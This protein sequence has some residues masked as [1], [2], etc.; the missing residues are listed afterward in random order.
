[1]NNRFPIIRST[2]FTFFAT[3][4]VVFGLGILTSDNPTVNSRSGPQYGDV[5]I[6]SGLSL[7]ALGLVL[8][9]QWAY[10]F[11]RES[12]AP[13]RTIWLISLLALNLFTAVILAAALHL[14]NT[15]HPL[16]IVGV[17]IGLGVCGFLFGRRFDRAT[18]VAE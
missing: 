15:L 18:G 16:A 3:F 12:A 5:A 6:A 10:W 2:G 8:Y 9:A 4:I 14:R 13:G 7:V 11:F 17:I 1:M